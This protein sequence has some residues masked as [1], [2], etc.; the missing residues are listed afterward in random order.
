MNKTENMYTHE[1]TYDE[2]SKKHG[3][4]RLKLN[5]RTIILHR[6]TQ[7]LMFV[8]GLVHAFVH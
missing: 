6:Q 1:S 5:Q 7:T 3:H 8:C 4:K 2:T